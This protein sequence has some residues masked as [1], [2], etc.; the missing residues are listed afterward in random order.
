MKTKKR[1]SPSKKQ[2]RYDSATLTLRPGSYKAKIKSVRKAKNSNVLV[3]TF[4]I[5]RRIRL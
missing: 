2:F 4:E 1:R 5:E 3:V